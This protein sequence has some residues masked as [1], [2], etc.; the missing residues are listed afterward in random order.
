MIWIIITLCVLLLLGIG[1]FIYLNEKFKHCK[2]ISDCLESN[3]RN[4]IIRK[5]N[6]IMNNTNSLDKTTNAYYLINN[7]II[8]GLHEVET[9]NKKIGTKFLNLLKDD[10]VRES[11]IIFLMKKCQLLERELNNL[12]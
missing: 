5:I 12:K 7:T 8:D 4:E 1:S 3:D 9:K 10:L 11:S 6:I 2:M